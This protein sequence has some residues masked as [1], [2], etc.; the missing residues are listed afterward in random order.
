MGKI[1]R[2]PVERCRVPHPTCEVC[3]KDY[4]IV[5]THR[6]FVTVT[7]SCEAVP[8]DERLIWRGG[9][10]NESSNDKSGDYDPST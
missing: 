10:T 3:N 6:D 7:H 9:L 4:E 2:F 8:F 5:E 1:I